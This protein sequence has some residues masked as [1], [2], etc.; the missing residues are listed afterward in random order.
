[1]SETPDS[2][3]DQST[4]H[5]GTSVVHDFTIAETFAD[6]ERVAILHNLLAARFEEAETILLDAEALRRA[7]YGADEL[8]DRELEA[9][10]VCLSTNNAAVETTP[11]NSY[12]E[13][14]FE[15]DVSRAQEV[16]DQ[17]FIAASAL[18]AQEDEDQEAH[19]VV[20]PVATVPDEVDITQIDGLSYTR[21]QVRRL[22]MNATESVRVA[23]PY[24]ETDRTVVEDL[25]SLPDQEIDTHILT[26]ETD[27]PSDELRGALND[28]HDGVSDEAAERLEVRDLYDIDA[29]SGLQDT[30]THA[31]LIIIDG[32]ACYVGS[33]NFTFH[34][35]HRN[36][37]FGVF[38]SG[39][40]ADVITATYD[41]VFEYAD[42]V[43]LPLH[44]P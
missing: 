35:L 42:R 9:V 11:G 18:A 22:L 20:T 3:D 32:E 4:L 13:Y 21:E 30:A 10:F 12:V 26:R 5:N 41:A 14:T 38:L 23:N 17:Q 27:S 34:S 28:L 39:P 40:P 37:E 24:F 15:V 33:A 31:K 6:P 16:L 2:P 25:A 19:P 8:T 36:F 1:M 29:E 43:D 7:W 44:E